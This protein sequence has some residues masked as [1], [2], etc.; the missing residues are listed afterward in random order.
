[1]NAEKYNL[2]R[3]YFGGCFIRGTRTCYVDPNQDVDV[4]ICRACGYNN[5]AVLCHPVLE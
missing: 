2:D 4:S 5:D 3:I 1:M